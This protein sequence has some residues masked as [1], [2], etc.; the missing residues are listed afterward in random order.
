[1]AQN[2]W[3]LKE[4]VANMSRRDDREARQARARREDRGVQVRA[5]ARGRRGI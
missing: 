5:V 2:E 4:A 1:M 3:A